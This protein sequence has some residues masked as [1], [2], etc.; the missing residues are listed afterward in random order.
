MNII[1]KIDGGLGKSIMA[2]AICEAIKKKYKKDNLIV[3]TSY[4]EV[5][6]CNPNIY[7]AYSHESMLYFYKDFIENKEIKAFLHNPYFEESFIKK[8]KHLLETWCEM[9]GLKYQGEKPKIYLSEREEKYFLNLNKFE[10]PL[11]ILQSNGGADNQQHKYSWARDIPFK[12][13]Q[14]IANEYSK[15]YTIF[16][17]RKPN[18]VELK[19][20]I[21]FE[22]N[23]RYLCVLIKYSTKRLLIDSFA[24][25]ASSAFDL[26]SV[27]LWIANDPKQFGYEHNINIVA[28]EET[29]TPDLKFAQFSKYNIAGEFIEFPYKSEDEIFNKED[30]I[31]AL[32]Q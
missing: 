15:D 19:N 30:I 20:T 26:Q 13:A 27:V 5:F 7:K 11:F 18:Q 29:K 12:L 9:F 25:H 1:F 8:E 23:F 6:L 21:N 2:T 22:T 31:N 28:N 4:P 3:I 17:V 14:E 10:K 24:Q 16:H 32:N